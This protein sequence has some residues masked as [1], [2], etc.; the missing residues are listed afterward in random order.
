MGAARTAEELSELLEARDLEVEQLRR[1]IRDL[2]LQGTGFLTAASHAV[3]NPLTIIQSYLE[4]LLSDLESGLSEQQVEFVTAAH[5]ATR[6]LNGLVASIV[7]LAALELGAAELEKNAVEVDNLVAEVRE[8]HTPL[9]E[10][11]GID[12]SVSIPPQLPQVSADGERLKNAIGA[13]VL[14]AVQRTP[15]GGRIRVEVRPRDAGVAVGI[16]D[17]GPGIAEDQLTRVFEPFV[18]LSR[19]AGDPNRGAGLGLSIARRQI[20]AMGGR[21]EV[22][23]TVGAGSSFDIWI[24]V[25]SP[26]LS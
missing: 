24:P 7:E 10:D 22:T 11:R 14:N 3:M 26:D 1:R 2:E 15:R 21:I 17:T 20:E 8:A 19:P 9:A 5:S 25:E 12:L 23:S 6:R 13:V 16:T 18:R 4:I